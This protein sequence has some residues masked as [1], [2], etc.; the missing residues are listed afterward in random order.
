MKP[1][2]PI[3]SVK[4]ATTWTYPHVGG[5]STHLAMLART[6]QLPDSDILS[7][8]DIT[9]RD[10]PFWKR[11]RRYLLSRIRHENITSHAERL[12]ELLR[13][14]NTDIIHCHDAM[15]TW[16]AGIARDRYKK[17][18]RIVTTVHGPV[19]RHMIEHGSSPASPEVKNVAA[20]ER[21]AWQYA[22]QIIAVDTTQKSI[23]CDQGADQTKIS[24]IANAV[25]LAEI[26]RTINLLPFRPD[27][28]R[29]ML[30]VPRR[31]APK[32]GV[33]HA[34]A[35][36]SYL[37]DEVVLVVA[38][39]G[40][41]HGKC[42][43]LINTL[44]LEGRVILLGGVPRDLVLMLSAMARATLIPSVP[45]HGIVEATSLAAIEAMA[46]RVPVVASAI[47]GLTELIEH[48]KTGLLVP[49][50]EPKAIAEEVR[51]LISND[52]DTANLTSV[53]RQRVEQRYSLPVWKDSI[54]R[55]YD[56]AL[57]TR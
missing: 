57:S 38:G 9:E 51:R 25:D 22:D 55:V 21:L 10:E 56:L 45:S 30:L 13:E 2:A 47:G 1:Q 12:V 18:Y 8:H 14:V 11:G 46:A 36:L 32:N 43:E 34:I 52:Y 42:V 19:S 17:T 37:P 23:C 50:G 27:E 20:K 48:Q 44:G 31:L 29:A 5:V 28:K 53:A 49:P 24:V 3:P 40:I 26:D 33:H 7:F 41:E 16:A 4:L 6:L 54:L 39:D 15:A 35:A